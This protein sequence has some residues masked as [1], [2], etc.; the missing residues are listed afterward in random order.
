MRWILGKKVL[1]LETHAVKSWFTPT[2][3]YC[4]HPLRSSMAKVLHWGKWGVTVCFISQRPLQ[5]FMFHSDKGY[6]LINA[7]KWFTR[8]SCAR[9]ENKLWSHCS[10]FYCSRLYSSRIGSRSLKVF[11]LQVAVLPPAA[12]KICHHPQVD[13]STSYRPSVTFQICP[14]LNFSFTSQLLPA[15]WILP[16]LGCSLRLCQSS[17]LRP[18]EQ[19]GSNASFNVVFFKGKVWDC[20]WCR[21]S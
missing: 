8:C 10:L 21:H 17:I 7:A 15:V 16:G 9:T 4:P 20:R 18:R 12:Q 6:T 2:V 1:I 14:Q 3:S 19:L 5:R 11:R 13:F